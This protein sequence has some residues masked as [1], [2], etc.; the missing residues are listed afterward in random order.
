MK[1]GRKGL[2]PGPSPRGRESRSLLN[3]D[4][5]IMNSEAHG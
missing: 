2:S 4:L 3:E 5:F 1:W